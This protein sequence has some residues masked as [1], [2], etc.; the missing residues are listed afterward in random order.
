MNMLVHIADR[1][2]GRPLLITPEKAEILLDV[3]AGRIG[4][5]PISAEDGWEGVARTL[6]AGLDHNAPLPGANRF[7]S[8]G[9][10]REDGSRGLVR[11]KGGVASITIDG[12]LVN[13]GAWI[14]ASSGLVSYE[15]I[16]A[17]LDEA[18]ND[19]AIH[20]IVLDLNSPGGEAGGM[21]ALAKAVRAAAAVKNVVAVVN[22]MAASAAYGIASAARDIVVSETSMVGSIGVVLLHMDRSKEMESKGVRPTLIHAGAHKVDGNPFAPL[23]ESVRTHMQGEV[24]KIYSLFLDA[25]AAGR[26]AR[27]DKN[28]AKKTEARV[29]LGEEAVS[30]GLADSVGTYEAV[31]ASLSSSRGT[32][33]STSGGPRMQTEQSP[34]AVAEGVQPAPVATA[35]ASAPVAPASD[36]SAIKARIKAIQSHPA[37]QGRA[38][39][40]SHLAFDTD[41]S[42]EAAAAI[43][44]KAPQAAAAAPAPAAAAPAE[45][46]SGKQA[47]GALGL[48]APQAPNADVMDGWKKAAASANQRFE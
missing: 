1:F 18:V 25:V 46:L 16:A 47:D 37:A 21:F 39:I 24:D 12:S 22:D 14:G 32:L 30:I 8:G 11:Q 44:E 7:N 17:Q 28:A 43:L 27:L 4:I 34:A 26:G 2:L 35:P 31:V 38:D 15:G 41:M 19:K 6:R 20:S 29:F 10:M 13:R 45:Y 42:V 33:I 40:A 48:G 9:S 5:G 23:P 3:L 36:A